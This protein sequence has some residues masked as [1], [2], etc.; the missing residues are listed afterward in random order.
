MALP[1]DKLAESLALL[2]ALQDAGHIA[3]LSMSGLFDGPAIMPF[4]GLPATGSRV[5]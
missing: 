5:P 4:D 3:I 1:S 2:K